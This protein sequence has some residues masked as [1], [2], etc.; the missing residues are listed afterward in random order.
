MNIFKCDIC[1]RE[2]FINPQCQVVKK[3]QTINGKE[4][5]IP[6]YVKMKNQNRSTGKMEEIDVPKIEDL[7]ERTYIV[8][9]RLGQEVVQRD[10]C[11]TCFDSLKEHFFNLWNK[12]E[13]MELA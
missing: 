4:I 6:E 7:Q 1:N 13:N 12:L 11:K 2:T 9:L 3:R 5:E 8:S 10:F